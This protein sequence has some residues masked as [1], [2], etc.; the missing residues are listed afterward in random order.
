MGELM[1]SK[2][3]KK[4]AEDK[5]AAEEAVQ[6]RLDDMKIKAANDGGVKD[7]DSKSSLVSKDPKDSNFKDSLVS[8]DSKDSNSKPLEIVEPKSGSEV[9]VAPKKKKKK[10]AK[11]VE[12]AKEEFG[13]VPKVQDPT[14][15]AHVPK[16]LDTPKVHD[17]PLD[18]VPQRVQDTPKIEDLSKENSEIKPSIVDKVIMVARW[19]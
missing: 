11:A 15:L 6:K 7:Q 14:K 17:V 4:A 1:K 16:A 9:V 18:H 12:K 19:L 8:K 2:V 3:N 13:E 10:V 5:K